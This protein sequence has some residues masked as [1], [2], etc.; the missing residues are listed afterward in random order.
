MPRSHWQTV[1]GL[2]PPSH[3]ATCRWGRPRS[4]RH[5][6]RR[7]PTSK[8]ALRKRRTLALPSPFTPLSSGSGIVTTSSQVTMAFA[9]AWARM[10]CS[11]E[12]DLGGDGVCSGGAFPARPPTRTCGARSGRGG[13]LAK[14]RTRTQPSRRAVAAAWAARHSSTGTS[15]IPRSTCL[16][17]SGGHLSTER[18]PCSVTMGLGSGSPRAA[19][20]SNTSGARSSRPRT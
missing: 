10:G 17:S 3:S 19:S 12:R 13:R 4:W 9:D 15:T 14:S 8:S 7:R 5:D 6:L 2:C 16:C 20:A 1:D 18:R 11:H